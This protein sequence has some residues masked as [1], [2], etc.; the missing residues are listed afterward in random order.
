MAPRAVAA[1]S[2]ISLRFA[3]IFVPETLGARL[4]NIM[5]DR[6]D[7]EADTAGLKIG[8]AHV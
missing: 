5:D 2:K 8:I 1:L 3:I 4:Q 7:T 6:T